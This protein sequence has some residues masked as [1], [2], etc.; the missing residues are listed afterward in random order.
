MFYFCTSLFYCLHL[1]ENDFH[2]LVFML[3]LYV[4]VNL[5][6]LICFSIRGFQ[7]SENQLEIE[8]TNP[9]CIDLLS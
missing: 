5:F 7:T 4:V 9:P 6:F 3:F 2:T 1:M 8:N